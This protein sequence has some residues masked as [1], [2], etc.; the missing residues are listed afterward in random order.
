MNVHA[1]AILNQKGGVGKTTTTA[2]LGIGLTQEGRKEGSAGGLRSPSKLV[3]QSGSPQTGRAV[4]Y[5]V[6]AHWAGT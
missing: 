2:N 5:P 1:I 6:N 4:R 3:D